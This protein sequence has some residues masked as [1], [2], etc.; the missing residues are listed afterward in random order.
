MEQMRMDY[1]G[2]GLNEKLASNDSPGDRT[3][4]NGLHFYHWTITASIGKSSLQKRVLRQC[5]ATDTLT[6]SIR[7]NTVDHILAL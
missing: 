2:N 4:E 1:K 6:S 5:R 7:G 3:S